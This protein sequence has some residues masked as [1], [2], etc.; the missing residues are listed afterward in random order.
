M[1][2]KAQNFNLDA[3]EV[4]NGL[5]LKGNVD[6]LPQLVEPLTPCVNSSGLCSCAKKWYAYGLGY[7][8]PNPDPDPFDYLDDD[9]LK[10]IPELVGDSV[11]SDDN[12]SD[13]EAS[14][15]DDGRE[16][17]YGN[18][19]ERESADEEINEEQESD[20]GENNEWEQVHVD[21]EQESD[22]EQESD[23]PTW[24]DNPL[25]HQPNTPIVVA[26]HLPNIWPNVPVHVPSRPDYGPESDSD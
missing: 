26:L 9:D 2:K 18:N 10:S 8:E 5:R 7:F 11:D 4:L 12:E 20:D 19:G 25:Q 3:L 13:A 16:P 14:D 21:E 22:A 23:I 6:R 15:D 17:V 1:D 24:F